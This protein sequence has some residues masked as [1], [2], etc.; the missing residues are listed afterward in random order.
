MTS[1]KNIIN[2][3]LANHLNRDSFIIFWTSIVIYSLGNLIMSSGHIDDRFSIIIMNLGLA[4]IAFSYTKLVK[5]SINNKYFM[6][7]FILYTFWQFYIIIHGFISINII[8]LITISSSPLLFLH[9]LVPFVILIPANIFFVKKMFD[10]FLFLAILL[11]IVFLL[12]AN[13]ILFTNSNFAEQTVWTLGTGG[14]FLLLTWEYHN[15]K[16]Q[17]VAFFT[18]LISLLISTITARRSIMLT[19][20]NFIVL[21]LII[22]ALSKSQSI[23]SKIYILTIVI[24]TTFIAYNIFFKY[25]DVLFSKITERFGDDTREAVITAFIS[26]MSTDDWI[27]GKGYNGQYYAPGIELNK[28]NRWFIESGYLQ[29]ILKGGIINLVLFLLIAI[30]AAYL[31]I[32]KSNNIL[33]KA[34][35]TIVL[36]WLI[37]MILWGMPGLSIRY[38]LLW[39]SIGICYSKVIRGFSE[40]EIKNSLIILGK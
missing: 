31:G 21:S 32:V 16:R 22:F 3:Y 4:G 38:I 14:G 10:Y 5:L 25:Q 37:D 11:F 17:V 7:V 29:T 40:T 28:D 30:P 6:N 12:F 19:F 15:K 20:I 26:D 24:S 8:T 27:Y 36:L 13:E 18:V 39:T 9:Y 35:G 1:L 34:A 33:S 23:K 2:Q